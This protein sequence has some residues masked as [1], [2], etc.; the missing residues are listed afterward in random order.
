MAAEL[1]VAVVAIPV[2][3]CVFDRAVHPLDLTICPPMVGFDQSTFDV[4]SLADQI[5][6][7][8]AECDAV[9]VPRLLCE[10]D[11]IVSENG[12]D[13]ARNAFQQVFQDLPSRLAIGFLNRLRHCKFACS[14]NGHKEMQLIDGMD[15]MRSTN[16]FTGNSATD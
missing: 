6:S 10:L 5:K 15:P 14:V 2:D 11:T 1:I 8:L 16:A 12:M 3:C 7:H 9:A 4:A 13:L